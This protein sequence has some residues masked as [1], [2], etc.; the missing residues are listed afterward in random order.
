[1]NNVFS[2]VGPED[3]QENSLKMT[4]SLLFKDAA[5]F[6]QFIEQTAIKQEC[7]C[8]NVLVEY[9]DEKDIEFDQISKLISQSLKGKLQKEFAELG[10]LPEQNTL[11]V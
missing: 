11:D 4:S 7:T 10:L 5:A 2:I 6:S 3:I 8:T 1:M 9:C